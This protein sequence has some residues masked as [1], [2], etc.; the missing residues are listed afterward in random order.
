MLSFV[1]LLWLGLAP[2]PAS[3][4]LESP[5]RHVRGTGAYVN[6]LLRD[7]FH[8]S[9]TFA[10][11][12]SR[13]ERSDVIVYV[14]LMPTLPPGLDGRLSLSSRAHEFRYLRIQLAPRGTF[15]E[16]I[17]TVG[18]ELQH[19]AEVAEAPDV[20]DQS[21]FVALYERIGLRSGWHQYETVKAQAAG[22]QVRKELA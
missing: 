14:E 5:L 1:P 17:A 3:A 19:A 13:I 7:G 12:M 11:L 6:E 2:V 16:M 21:A 10:H 22:R 4:A 15:D 18:H 20:R 9:P 8:R